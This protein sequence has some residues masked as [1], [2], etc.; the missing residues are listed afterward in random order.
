MHRQDKKAEPAYG[1][2]T[3]RLWAAT[4]EYWHDMSIGPVVLSQTAETMRR[5]RNS[6]RF[7]LGNIGPAERRAGSPVQPNLTLVRFGFRTL[8]MS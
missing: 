1:A 6:V 2:D 4:V 5:I 8:F 7:I 3:L